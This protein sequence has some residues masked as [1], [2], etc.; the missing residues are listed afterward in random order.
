MADPKE[1]PTAEPSTP[2][3][4]PPSRG[5]ATVYVGDHVASRQWSDLALCCIAIVAFT[6]L[7]ALRR[8]ASEAT[9]AGITFFGQ[10]GLALLQIRVAS[11]RSSS[12]DAQ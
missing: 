7:G 2:P 9:V 10:R 3:V 12:G 1:L 4:R 6:V 11:S 8:I 5:P